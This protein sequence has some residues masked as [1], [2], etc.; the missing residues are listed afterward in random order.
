VLVIQTDQLTRTY[1][2]R[3][4]ISDVNLR[5]PEG[6]LY[7]FLGPNGAGKTTTMRVL[8]GFLEPTMGQAQV[9]GLDCWRETA[10]IKADVGYIPGDLRLWPWLTGNSAL[11][12]FSSIRKREMRP[13][14]R[15]LAEILGLDLALKVR[16]MSKGTRQKLGLVLAMAHKPRL[17]VLDEPSSG[18]DPLM[19]DHFRALLREVVRDGRTVLLSS[20]TLGEVEDLCERVAIVRQGR[21][22]ADDSLT[23]L[24]ASSGHEVRI[25]WRDTPAADVAPPTI[26]TLEA[27]VGRQWICRLDG[28]VEPL[29][30]YL[31]DEASRGRGIDD[32][33]IDRPDLESLFRKFYSEDLHTASPAASKIGGSW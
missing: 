19:Q 14:G 13:E 28:P 23:A 1:G 7:G 26:L 17:L 4:G 20:H 32:L 11:N 18:L 27:R 9:F 2:V 24:R 12:L 33:T 25:T 22:I 10:R 31:H 29:L 5:V 15:R 30:T 8:L 3:R 21:I 16:K 6:S